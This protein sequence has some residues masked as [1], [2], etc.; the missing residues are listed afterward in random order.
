[1]DNISD[2]NYIREVGAMADA[3]MKRYAHHPA[4]I[5]VG[6]DNEIGNGFM[7]YSEA[8]RQRFITWLMQKYPGTLIRDDS[9]AQLKLAVD[10][11]GLPL[12]PLSR[13][14]SRCAGNG[15]RE[16]WQNRL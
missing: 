13:H 3:L 10:E 16:E 7:S 1:M 11:L 14:L 15:A 9:Q 8:D 2:P 5:A 4:V 12:H 6:Y